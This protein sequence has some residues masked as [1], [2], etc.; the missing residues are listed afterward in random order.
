[1]RRSRLFAANCFNP[2][3]REGAT[4][5]GFSPQQVH[6]V[7]IHAPAKGRPLKTVLLVDADTFQST[8]P[9]RGDTTSASAAIS[10]WSFNPR[11]REGATSSGCICIGNFEFQSTPP[12]RGDGP[13]R[14]THHCNRRFNPRPREGATGSSRDICPTGI[15]SIHAPAKGRPLEFNLLIELGEL[16]SLRELS[17]PSRKLL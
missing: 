2:R 14:P 8:P 6:V 12:R 3:P 7:S 15:V 4:R 11:P 9:R 13:P 1:M 16:C 17:I 5:R 10:I